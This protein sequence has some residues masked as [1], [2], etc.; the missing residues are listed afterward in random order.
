MT[1]QTENKLS[2][3]ADKIGPHSKNVNNTE[4][5]ASTVAGG[6]MAQAYK[7]DRTASSDTSVITAQRITP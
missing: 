3:L 6:V 5:V 2:T 7:I 4:R 1:E